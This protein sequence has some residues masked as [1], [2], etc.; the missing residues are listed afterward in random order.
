MHK[1]TFN[2][3]FS[4]F[5]LLCFTNCDSDP[6]EINSVD[7]FDTFLQEEMEAQNLP[8]L[9]VLIFKENQVLYERNLGMANIEQGIELEN[10]H[11]FLMASVSKVVTGTALMQLHEAGQF[12]LDDN[13]NDYL[14]FSVS[15]PNQT[16]DITFRMLLTHTSGIADGS[17]Q[18]DEYYYGEDSPKALAD[19][20]ES[21]LSPTGQVYDA[22]E[23]FH[24]FE[25]G[26]RHEYSNIG[27]ALIGVLVEEIAGIDF[28]EYCKQNIFNP[29][30]MT[31]TTW[32][33]DE[34]SGTIVMPYNY[35]SRDYDPIGHYTFTDYPNGGLR[36]TARDMHQLFLAFMQG[37]EVNNMQL[38]E[39]AT[40]DAM[41]SPQIPDLDDE[42]GLHLFVMDKT[43]DLWGH[44]GGE[45]GVATVVAFNRENNI[46]AVILTN[47]G[48]AELDEILQAAYQLGEGF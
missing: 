29:L 3:L 11:P 19:Y 23:N 32:R 20:L 14:P 26:S 16:T 40:V 34:I 24:N 17:S 22:N 43:N 33:L 21:Y 48:D 30:G 47:Q 44:D 41:L 5:L 15:I 36:S 42:V 8:A 6:I 13:I 27:S 7:E 12:E 46:G 4:F 25:P 38:L 28:N 37:G 18:D 1:F 2:L 45:Q 9:S 39:S 31:N 10:D 35:V